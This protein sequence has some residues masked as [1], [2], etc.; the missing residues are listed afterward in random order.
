[1]F[2][3]LLIGHGHSPVMKSCALSTLYDS[4]NGI[5][6]WTG[7]VAQQKPWSEPVLWAR[8]ELNPRP[9]PCQIQ[10]SISQPEF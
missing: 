1:L 8:E 9:L 5:F 6:E 10:R 4:E 2:P 3:Q 7:H